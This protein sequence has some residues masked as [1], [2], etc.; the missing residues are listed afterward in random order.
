[1]S[2][3]RDHYGHLD[4]V[5]GR[6]GLTFGAHRADSIYPDQ[7]PGH[8]GWMDWPETGNGSFLPSGTYERVEDGTPSKVGAA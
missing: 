6:C 1:M 8:E 7:C 4:E 2:E 5:C 3:A